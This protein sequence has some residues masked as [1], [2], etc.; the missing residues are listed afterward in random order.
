[1]PKKKRVHN[2][3]TGRSYSYDKRYAARP[4]Q[5]KRRAQRNKARRAAIKSG[6]V[7]KGDGKDV[8]HGAPSKKGSLSKRKTRV[9]SSSKNR[10]KNGHKKGERGTRRK[11]K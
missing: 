11:K 8:D 9:M 7:R 1:M 6:A 2:K 4:E 5:R 10:A 3:S